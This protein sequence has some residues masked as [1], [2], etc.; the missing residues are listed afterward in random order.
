MARKSIKSN[1]YLFDA[2]AREVVIPGGVQREQLI[3]ITNVT[4]NK[5][6][7]NFS[8]PELTATTYS[9]QT[10]IRNVTTT[11][12]V[13]SYDTTSMSDTDKLQ[14]I[15]DDF[16]ET[17]KPAETYFDAVNK[18]RMS[19]PQS[20]IDTDFEY[21]T[22]DTKWEA[23][24]MI[25]NNPFAFKSQDAIVITD[26]QAVENS[27][28]ITVSVNTSLST[29]PAAGTA[30]Y[31]QDTTFPGANGVFIIDSI[32]GVNTANFTFTAKYEWTLASGGIYDSARTALYSGIHYT[33]SDVGGS[34]TLAASAGLMA[35]AVQVDTTQAH[36]FEVGN[37][38]AIAGSDGTNVNGSWVVARVETPTRF[39]YFP[40]AAPTGSVN[41]GTRKLYPRPQGNSIHRAF[42]GGVKF[43]TNTNSKN[44]QAI[45]QTKRYFRYQSGK[46]VS[47]STGSILEPAIENLDNITSSGTTVTVVAADAHNVTRDTQV[48]VR[49][50]TDNNYNG[51]HQVTNVIDREVI[52]NKTPQIYICT[53]RN[54]NETR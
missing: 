9:I 11:R 45:R 13:L 52:L 23:L 28:E 50:V 46:G 29:R 37:E 24:S 32:D 22:Q 4:S 20:Q 21:G 10:D 40:D 43:S 25:N 51:V 42:D 54:N 33:G 12:V 19:Q 38:I 7:Y 8:D 16:E 6:I 26:V 47:F 49:G 36:G 27:R 18:Q 41:S 3:L 2:S 34:I 14:I 48:D 1:Y 17:V 15:Y 44:Q 5:V 30:I 53:S 31:I 35:G 39:Y